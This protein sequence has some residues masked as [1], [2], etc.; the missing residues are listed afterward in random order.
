MRRK[1]VEVICPYCRKHAELVDSAVVYG[2]SYGT[3]LVL[4]V[5]KPTAKPNGA[6][7]IQ[8]I[9][10]GWIHTPPR[11]LPS[12]DRWH[13]RPGS[14]RAPVWGPPQLKRGACPR[15]RLNRGA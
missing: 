12:R 6:A 8:V 15:R 7:I 4:D 5:F 10:G 11:L 1:P 3:A 9:S 2:R 14:V 13:V